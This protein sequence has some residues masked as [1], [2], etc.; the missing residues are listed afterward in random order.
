MTWDAVMKNISM[1]VLLSL[2]FLG[3]CQGEHKE[4][5]DGEQHQD[6]SHMNDGS[7][8]NKEMPSSD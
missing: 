1:L 4:H 7:G 5:N 6:A 3:A 8:D 2:T